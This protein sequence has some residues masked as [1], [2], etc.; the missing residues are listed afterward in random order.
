[1]S[2]TVG[3]SLLTPVTAADAQEAC[4]RGGKFVAENAVERLLE[5]AG[6]S[7][8]RREI[9]G[10][11]ILVWARLDQA[12]GDEDETRI[13]APPRLSF[14]PVEAA[15]LC[16][17]ADDSQWL[18]EAHCWRRGPDGSLAV[19]ELST[20]KPFQRAVEAPVETIDDAAVVKVATSTFQQLVN[21]LGPLIVRAVSATQGHD[22]DQRPER[23]RLS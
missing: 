4:W 15:D 22:L 20:R 6:I 11:P 5:S 2:Q 18:V 14:Y 17:A 8:A 13:S 19:Y 3:A 7:L 23:D 9:A 12:S 16:A 1:M 21:E 10:Q